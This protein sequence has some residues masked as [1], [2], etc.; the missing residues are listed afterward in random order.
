MIDRKL[1]IIIAGPTGS[2]KSAY[3]I[4]IAQQNS[5][6][7]ICADSRQVYRDMR[8]GTASPSDEDL[9]TV[10]HLGFNCQA[11]TEH[12]DAGRF[13]N[14]T[15][16]FIED[17]RNRNKTPIIVGGTGLYLRCLRFGF[18]DKVG[19]SVV[20]REG[21]ESEARI[22]GLA[23]LHRK[24]EHADPLAASRIHPNDSVRIIRALE[25]CESNQLSPTSLLTSHFS[26]K[27]KLEANWL[28]LWPERQE[29]HRRLA[30]RIQ[31]MFTAGLI[32]EA[33]YLRSIL[34]DDHRLLKTMGYEESLQV[35]DG[36]I[37]ESRAR[38]LVLF[39]QRQYA[40]RQYTWFRKEDWWTHVDGSIDSNY[41]G[42]N[43]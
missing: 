42:T 37:S 10:E 29:L 12:Y 27:V 43:K 17:V 13:V 40:K 5:G 14:D 24:L 26:D 32:Q 28:L 22:E 23:A 20:V 35:I 2:G 19:K 9:E 16:A 36:K 1:P 7:I 39:R 15:L 4:K 25:I 30:L 18:D 8:I 3:A 31:C 41:L 6:V 34:P 21:L 38:E 11:P 33:V